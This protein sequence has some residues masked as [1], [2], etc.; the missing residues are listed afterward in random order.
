[1]WIT[2]CLVI[3]FFVYLGFS[4]QEKQLR[5]LALDQLPIAFVKQ[6]FTKYYT[7]NW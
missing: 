1:M 2:L 3:K 5:Y 7:Q 6:L 4:N